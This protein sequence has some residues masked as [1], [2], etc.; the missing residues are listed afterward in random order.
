[1]NGRE[2]CLNMMDITF[3]AGASSGETLTDRLFGLDMQLIA[4][5]CITALNVFVLFEQHKYIQCRNAGISN[6]LHVKSEQ[7][8]CKRFTG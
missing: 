4:D 2:T 1:M 6:Q 7:P 3:L 5:T 8:V